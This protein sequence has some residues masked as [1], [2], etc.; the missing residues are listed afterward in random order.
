MLALGYS[1]INFI[2][3]QDIKFG[4]IWLL[5]GHYFTCCL[6]KKRTLLSLLGGARLFKHGLQQL[7]PLSSSQ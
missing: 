2:K 4:I 1:Y 5:C 7:F 3:L 6:H